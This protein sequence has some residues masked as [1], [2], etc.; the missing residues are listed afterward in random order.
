MRRSRNDSREM[1]VKNIVLQKAMNEEKKGSGADFVRV[2]FV[3]PLRIIGEQEGRT[4]VN[5]GCKKALDSS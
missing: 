3:W 1:F 2:D 5:G 4:V